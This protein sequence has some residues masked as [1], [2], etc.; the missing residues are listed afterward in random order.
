MNERTYCSVDESVFNNAVLQLCQFVSWR[1]SRLYKTTVKPNSV[2]DTQYTM[3]YKT[4]HQFNVEHMPLWFVIEDEDVKADE[5]YLHAFK[6][7]EEFVFREL[8][9]SYLILG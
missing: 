6:S 3:I 5:L 9:L 8:A 7:I 2:V 4:T 1:L